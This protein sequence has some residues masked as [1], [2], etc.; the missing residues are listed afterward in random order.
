MSTELPPDGGDHRPSEA[1]APL[2]GPAFSRAGTGP[3]LPPPE[4]PAWRPLRARDGVLGGVCRGFAEATGVDLTLVRLAFVAA[5]LSGFGVLAYL[6]LWM[7]VP[8]EDASA[9][10]VLVPAPPD[11]SRWLR[12]GLL[13]GGLVG[14][15]SF[16]WRWSF[17][18]FDPFPWHGPAG[19]GPGLFVGLLLVAV[20][21]GVIW[22]RRREEVRA[23]RWRDG[24]AG[25]GASDAMPDA[26]KTVTSPLVTSPPDS[27]SPGAP[28]AGP[29]TAGTSPPAST[30]AASSASAPATPWPAPV[31]EDQPGGPPPPSA[32][33]PTAAMAPPPP[34]RPRLSGGVIALRVIAWLAVIGAILLTALAGI[35]TFVVGALSVTLPGLA[36]VAMVAAIIGVVIAA[37]TAR[38]VWP[39]LLALV[40]LVGAMGLSAGLARWDGK[41][42]KQ[43]LRP[44]TVAELQPTYD[45]AAGHFVLDLS[46][47]AIAEGSVP[48]AIDQGV[49]RLDVVVPHDAVVR[50]DVEVLGGEANIFDTSD[51]GA[52]IDLEVVDTPVDPAGELDLRIELGFGQANVCR[53]Q[54][55][56]PVLDGCPG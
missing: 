54:P 26:F 56:V 5:G 49:G 16:A 10:R 1:Q 51:D 24:R 11:T 22:F 7:V 20:G 4:P 50:A 46:Q 43:V 47:V 23:G 33:L 12:L 3:G 21:V 18:W 45:F 19:R 17:G 44:Q 55:G 42:G 39:L 30:A 36:L 2:A 31:S 6:V 15:V 8:R 14:L 25:V 29:A 41:V 52:G 13:V 38:T 35:L 40:L 53:A 9:G 28:P 32:P 48:I 34:R 37:T 27:T